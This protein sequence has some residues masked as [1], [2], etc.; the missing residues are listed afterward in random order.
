MIEC[1]PQQL[2]LTMFDGIVYGFLHDAEQY[3][4]ILWQQFEW[5][6]VNDE[7]RIEDFRILYNFQFIVDGV[8]EAKVGDLITIQA[9]AQVAEIVDGFS[10]QLGSIFY[11]QFFFFSVA[12]IKRGKVELCQAEYLA[13]VVVYFLGD[14]A[15]G[16]FLD[17]DAGLE[18]GLGELGLHEYFVPDELVFPGIKNENYEY[19]ENGE[20]E[21]NTRAYQDNGFYVL[22][23][24]FLV[25]NSAIEIIV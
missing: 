18:E 11:F 8:F 2:C 25:H 15:K 7:F 24:V 21:K 20:H 6:S 19:D 22:R 14:G 10:N 1:Y 23:N 13:N 4:F 17:L 5:I 16:L 9:P 3:H 12:K